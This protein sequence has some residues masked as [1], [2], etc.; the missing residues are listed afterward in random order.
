M[1]LATSVAPETSLA[2]QEFMLKK[3][4]ILATA[5]AVG[6]NGQSIAPQLFEETVVAQDAHTAREMIGGRV[7]KLVKMAAEQEVE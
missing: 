6:K 1:V 5:I 2:G 4:G 7:A 3:E